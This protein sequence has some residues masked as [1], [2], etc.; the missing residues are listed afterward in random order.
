MVRFIDYYL[1]INIITIYFQ[2]HFIRFKILCLRPLQKTD[3]IS[4]V[5]CNIYVLI[6]K[7][8]P[9]TPCHRYRKNV[10]VKQ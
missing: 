9:G 5:V 8:L 10:P 6:C 2:G 4:M 7:S 1:T 3:Y